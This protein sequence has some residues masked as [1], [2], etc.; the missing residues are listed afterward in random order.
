MKKKKQRSTS[1]HDFSM[2][3]GEGLRLYFVLYWHLSK[4]H[5]F[6]F[7]LLYNRQRRHS[8]GIYFIGCLICIPCKDYMF[9]CICITNGWTSPWDKVTL[10][11]KPV[12]S[13]YPRSNTISA[14]KILLSEIL[15][16]FM[17]NVAY[18]GSPSNFLLLH[19]PPSHVDMTVSSHFRV[20]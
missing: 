3:F 14:L 13:H 9:D 8:N 1:N 15:N 16:T 4:K 18:G 2:F 20:I 17:E 11:C 12:A 5:I 19:H 6:I 7:S 10:R